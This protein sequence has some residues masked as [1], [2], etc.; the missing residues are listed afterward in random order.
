M[1][2]WQLTVPTSAD[3]EDAL[4]NF[5]WEQGAL[6]VVEEEAPGEVPRLRA[7]FA[8]SASSTGLL[9]A[10]RAYQASLRALGVAVESQGPEITPLLDEAWASAWQQSFPAREVGRRL[11]V[12]PPWLERSSGEASRRRRVIIEPGRAFGTGHHGT[13]EG[14]LVLLEEALAP[15]PPARVL[16][17]GTGTGILAIAALKLGVPAALAI[18]VDPDA[19]AA[20]QVNAERNACPGLAVR[21]AEPQEISERFP[22]VLANLLTHAHLAL[23]PHYERLVAPGGSLILGGM[24]EQEDERVVEALARRGFAGRSRL[25]LEGWASRRLEAMGR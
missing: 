25:V 22:L 13:T 21:L 1:P 8:E 4:T 24:L 3:N 23:A 15:T 17:I 19:V 10:V 12:L 18:D 6:G 5:L 16:D 2:F 7:F 20:A 14:C 9:A 11:L